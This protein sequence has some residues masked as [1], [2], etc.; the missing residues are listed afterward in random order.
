MRLKLFSAATLAVALAGF[1]PRVAE[2]EIV[3]SG[4][5]NITALATN[6]PLSFNGGAWNYGIFQGGTVRYA[7]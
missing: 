5:Q 3:W 7:Y 2:A 1:G 6:S 4:V